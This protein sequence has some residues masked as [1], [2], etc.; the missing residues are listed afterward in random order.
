MTFIDKKIIRFFLK[1]IKSIIF[2]TQNKK[3]NHL[4]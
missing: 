3:M 1:K 4:D 2:A